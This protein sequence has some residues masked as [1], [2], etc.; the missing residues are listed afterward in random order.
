VLHNGTTG[1]VEWFDGGSPYYELYNPFKVK[2]TY[3]SDSLVTYRQRERHWGVRIDENDYFYEDSLDALGRLA[4]AK[5][6]GTF[7]KIP[8]E[9]DL[10]NRTTFSNYSSAIT[11][12]DDNL[13]VVDTSRFSNNPS[14]LVNKI[15]K[16]EYDAF[17]QLRKSSVR[18]NSSVFEMKSEILYNYLGL[19][20]EDKNGMNI[21]RRH[22]YDGL[23]RVLEILFDDNSTRQYEYEPL[24]SANAYEKV[25]FTDEE[26]K[27][28]ETKYDIRGNLV[29]EKIGINQPTVFEYNSLNQLI[30]ITS[31]EGKITTYE[32]DGFGN[33]SRRITPDEGTYR[34]KYDT[35]GNL[36]FIMH[37]TSPL[38]LVFHRYDQLGRLVSTGTKS[39]TTTEF[40]NLNPDNTYS[41]E[42]TTSNLLAVNQYDEYSATGVFSNMGYIPL[43]TNTRGRLVSTAFR[44]RT[45]DSWNFKSYR[46]DHLGRVDRYWFKIAGKVVKSIYNYH[47]NL[48]NLIRQNI[49]SDYHVWY[50]YDVQ[51]RLT[52]SRSYRYNQYGS[53]HID[54][55]YEY[56][57]ADQVRKRWYK[58]ASGNDVEYLDYLYN[59]RGWLQRVENPD[60]TYRQTLEYYKNGNVKQQVMRHSIQGWSDL[61]FNYT[62]DPMNRL[63]QASCSGCSQHSETYQYDNDG[64]IERLIRGTSKD[65]VYSYY[66]GRNRL[67]TVNNNAG[68]GSMN[69]YYN[70]KGA[71]TSVY[72]N[73]TP[74]LKYFTYDYR[75]MPVQVTY[76]WENIDTYHYYYDENGMRVRREKVGTSSGREYYL[77]DH[78]GREVAIYDYNSNRIKMIN[79][80]GHGLE[81]KVNV[82][83]QYVCIP[84]GCSPDGCEWTWQ[85]TDSKYYYVKDHLGNIRVT[86][87]QNGN[88]ASARDYYPYGETL[89]AYTTAGVGDRYQ[90]TEKERDAETNLDYFGARYYDGGIIRWLTPD[91]LADKYYGWS[92]YN[93]VL[94]NP[95]RYVDPDGR[96]VDDY[97]VDSLGNVSFIRETKDDFDVLYSQDGKSSIEV[98][99]GI[100]N[101]IE[102]GEF[103]GIPFKYL[104]VRG[105][106]DASG[107]FEFL[108]RNSNVEWSQIKFGI[109]RNYLS[110][111]HEKRTEVGGADLL[112]KL[113]V[114]K[115]TIREYIH[116]HPT[117]IRGPSGFNPTSP[118]YGK[119]D[120]AFAEWVNTYAPSVR[121]G[122]YEVQTGKYIYY[123]HRGVLRP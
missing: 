21:R 79:L 50:N 73:I 23:G 97:M 61:T 14:N 80:F 72:D 64:N 55:E 59:S 122:V 60:Y 58:N 78:T 106:K 76:E 114:G 100:L 33:V 83:W 3:G 41:F 111:S 70:G 49:A 53:S 12:D 102:K 39:T 110:T 6:P 31:P 52:Q 101:N 57:Q 95:L 120:K 123:N 38:Q 8:D 62:Y 104:D 103:E 26:G 87:Q 22:K 42:T 32:Y 119:G 30:K 36:R 20:R 44:D 66:T 17:G 82:D 7:L 9:N 69:F 5:S 15:V 98:K 112:H 77:R 118:L 117:G 34:Y 40:N 113:V 81:G 74:V 24:G 35:Y 105:D 85:R 121:L 99:K 10:W 45:T 43:V 47:D 46:Y 37:T 19:V 84:S 93:Y 86:L 116:S 56:N 11:Y 88:L 94:G 28:R 2:T 90:L 67:Q 29:S 68:G 65:Y 108:A 25:I 48:D 109:N 71:V 75:N 63:T 107:L 92:P 16:H 13:I 18:N 115:Y 54:S 51:G 4:A 1:T 89:R 27:T 96:R 91:P